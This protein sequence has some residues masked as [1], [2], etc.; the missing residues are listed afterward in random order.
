M[1]W[2]NGPHPMWGMGW[3]F[4][5]IGIVFIAVI[6][7]VIS[8]FFGRG[9]PFCGGRRYDEI[10]DLRREVRELKDEVAKLRRKE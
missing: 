1:W 2:W 3:I 6:L 8:R 10:D 5:L 9:G 7:F 4:P